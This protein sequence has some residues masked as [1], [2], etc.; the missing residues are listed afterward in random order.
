MIN[1][2]NY[3]QTKLKK[4][5]IWERFIERHGEWYKEKLGLEKS[6]ESADIL[7]PFD[8]THATHKQLSAIQSYMKQEGISSL[9]GFQTWMR[10]NEKTFYDVLK[11]S[12]EE[13]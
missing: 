9:A 6:L 2:N 5:S 7:K 11:E 4:M 12:Y 8:L 3:K 10:W 13:D 1:G